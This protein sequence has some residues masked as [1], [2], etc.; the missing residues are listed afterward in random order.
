MAFSFPGKRRHSGPDER[1]A[2]LRRLLLPS[3]QD[4]DADNN[5]GQGK[6][7]NANDH[8]GLHVENLLSGR[9]STREGRTEFERNQ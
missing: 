4:D 8:A 7:H 3:A 2:R 1:D 5:D 9:P 6:G